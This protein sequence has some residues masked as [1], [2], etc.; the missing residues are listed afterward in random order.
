MHVQ[1]QSYVQV[2]VQA[3]VHV[4]AQAWRPLRRSDVM[5]ACMCPY[6]FMNECLHGGLQ[7][8]TPYV[9]MHACDDACVHAYTHMHECMTVS[10]SAGKQVSK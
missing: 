6:A 7:V 10:L 2:C 4:C 9:C 1:L 3:C 5:T 8:C